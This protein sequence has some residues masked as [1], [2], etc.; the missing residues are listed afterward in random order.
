MPARQ[1]KNYFVNPQNKF[2]YSRS[3]FKYERTHSTSLVTGA[4][5][6]MAVLKCLPGTTVPNKFGFVLQSAPLIGPSVD[7]VYIDIISVWTPTRLVMADFNE[8]LGDNDTYAWTLGN[9]VVEPRIT[10]IYTQFDYNGNQMSKT[11]YAD[12]FLGPHIGFRFWKLSGSAGPSV[13]DGSAGTQVHKDSPFGNGIS[14]LIPRIYDLTWNRLFR[15]ENIQNPILFS[16]QSGQNLSLDV[17]NY[18][19]GLG[20]LHFAN[21]LKDVF[22]LARFSPAI[23]TIDIGLGKD[24][25]LVIPQSATGIHFYDSNGADHSFYIDTNGHYEGSPAPGAARDLVGTNLLADLSQLT[26][27][28]LYYSI[29][30]QKYMNKASNGRRPVEFYKTMFGISK[31]NAAYDDPELLSQKRYRVNI[32]RVIATGQGEDGSGDYSELGQIGAYSLTSVGGTL[33]PEFTASE[34]GVLIVYAVIRAQ[35]SYASGIDKHLGDYD[36]LSTY[37][38]VFDHIGEMAIDF[39]EIGNYPTASGS[40]VFG[41]QE[42][43]YNYRYQINDVVGAFSPGQSLEYMTLCRDFNANLNAFAVSNSFIRQTPKEFDRMLKLPIFTGTPG[44][45]GIDSNGRQ[46]TSQRY[47]W[48]IQFALAGDLVATMSKDSEPLLFGQRI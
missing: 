35:E 19:E 15:N 1:I 22:N 40:H 36:L 33:F 20:R 45:T 48:V 39:A 8:W 13:F 27:N 10:N 3:V 9:N 34:Y 4:I 37:L 46:Y 12:N 44:A 32:S 14:V 26:V 43:W 11:Y 31:S 16:K 18:R 38:P 29:M 25:P 23:Q 21:R 30:L 6:P 2:D 28:S 41:Y 24:L 5:V 7:N 42:A 17:T 47:Q